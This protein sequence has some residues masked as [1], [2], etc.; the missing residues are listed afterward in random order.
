[1]AAP[2][3]FTIP[4]ELASIC[5]PMMNE[6]LA[7]SDSIYLNNTLCSEGYISIGSD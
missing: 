3:Q 1:M 2:R 6:V 7:K 5:P 4:V